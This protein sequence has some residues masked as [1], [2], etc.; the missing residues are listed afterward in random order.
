MS[1][2]DRQYLARVAAGPE[3]LATLD[4]VQRLEAAIRKRY[5]T[6]PR[7][8]AS[9]LRVAWRIVED[10]GPD[11]WRQRIGEVA[12][13]LEGSPAAEQI[14]TPGEKANIA[15]H[16]ADGAELK[17]A[18]YSEAKAS[19][20]RKR[21]NGGNDHGKPRGDGVELSPMGKAP[22]VREINRSRNGNLE[23]T[24]NCPATSEGRTNERPTKE[25]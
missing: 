9:R 15:S 6:S 10:F 7:T 24:R 21:T 22:E 2:V 1:D 18:D 4:Q 5:G 12:Q 25:T 16:G 14:P 8:P 17:T 13:L 3:P 19:G 23:E 11:A 20:N